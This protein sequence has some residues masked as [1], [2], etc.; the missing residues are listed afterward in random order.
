MKPC[1]GA[2]RPKP[3]KTAGALM[4]VTLSVWLDPTMISL[5]WAKVTGAALLLLIVTLAGT[6][7]GLASDRVT[8]W[9]QLPSLP[10][11]VRP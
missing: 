5:A 11:G 9:Y 2:S 7:P 8:G 1:F 6:L 3:A 10:A 4:S